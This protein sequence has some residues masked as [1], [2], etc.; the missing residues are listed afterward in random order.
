MNTSLFY[1]VQI[2]IICIF[3]YICVAI[4]LYRSDSKYKRGFLTICTLA[5]IECL[6]GI[7]SRT[8]NSIFCYALFDKNEFCNSNVGSVG[9]FSCGF[10]FFLLTIPYLLYLRLYVALGNFRTRDVKILFLTV[11]YII[12]AYMVLSSPFNGHIQF[13]TYHGAYVHGRYYYVLVACVGFY[14][15]LGLINALALMKMKVEHMVEFSIS[16]FDFF[17]LYTTAT[18]PFIMQPINLIVDVPTAGPSYAI[19]LFFLMSLHQHLRISIDDLTSI[20]NRNELKTYLSSLVELDDAKRRQTYMVFIDVNK[21][22]H[23]NDNYG[24]QEGDI[25]LMQISR[26]LKNVADTFNCF[27]C[28]YGGDEFI[29]IKKDA[30]EE[31]AAGVCHYIDEA[32]TRLRTLSLAPYELSV[33]TGYV[34]FDKRFKDVRDFIEAA[35]KL[36]YESKRASKKS[37]EFKEKA[38]AVAQASSPAQAN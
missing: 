13:L 8:A 19:A 18:L 7:F 16:K 35:D 33:S 4:N 38:Q 37:F 31:R 29:L 32:V 36:M 21:F 12:V 1:T 9:F 14:S 24:H 15:V 17:M 23:I 30:N 34:K 2:D 27:L 28:R 20:N 6:F 26:L 10:S 22:K 25:V 3:V 11:P 5:V